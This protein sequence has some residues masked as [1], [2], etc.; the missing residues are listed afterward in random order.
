MA[1]I[2]LPI[3]GAVV[4]SFFGNPAA[5][6]AIGS[7]IGALVDPV[8]GPDIT[9]Q[10]ARLSDL[11]VTSSTYGGVIP[12]VYGTNRLAG[13]I[14][15]ALPL[16]EEEVVEKQETGG[17]GGGGGSVTT[18]TYNYYATFAM[19]LGEGPANGLIRIWADGKLLYSQYDESDRLIEDPDN[20]NL[21]D[22]GY[23]GFTFY[24]GSETQTPTRS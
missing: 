2:V 18:T 9:Q 13:N 22:L 16:I 17:K 11:S 23:E 6:W 5:G 8:E 10:G 20:P 4:G 14:I 3:A 24:E 19:A 12:L 7:A 21:L 1:R 15:W